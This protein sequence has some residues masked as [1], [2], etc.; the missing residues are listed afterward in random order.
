MV[1]VVNLLK[2]LAVNLLVLQESWVL[3]IETSKL[4][5]YF[6]D[7]LFYL[8][9]Y[10]SLYIFLSYLIL[11][12]YVL[13]LS[14]ILYLPICYLYI[15]FI[16]VSLYMF[17]FYLLSYISLYVIFLYLLFYLFLPSS[18][19]SPVLPV[20]AQSQVNDLT[21]SMQVPGPQESSKQSSISGE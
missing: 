8:L 2:C 16:S 19:S 9:S 18:Q 10:I 17:S 14:L 7:H 20:P 21:P 12:L 13:F 5:I 4:I 1:S 3:D 15:F 6:I 11:S